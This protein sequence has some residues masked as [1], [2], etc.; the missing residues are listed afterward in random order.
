[1]AA[2][3]GLPEADTAR[4]RRWC[5]QRIPERVRDQV[6]IVCEEAARHLTIVECR[7]LW[8]DDSESEGTRLP[9][10]RLGYTRTTG[11]WTRYYRDRSLRFRR[12]DLMPPTAN[13]GELL[14]EIDRDPTA[15]FWG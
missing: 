11:T 6:R 14:D 7:A 15:I 2:P 3:Q 5:D 12:Y 13:V 4:V 1:M 8:H 10:A 9:V